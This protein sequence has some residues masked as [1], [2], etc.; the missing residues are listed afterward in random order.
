[1]TK[2]RSGFATVPHGHG[3]MKLITGR[4]YVQGVA[5]VFAI[6]WSSF[7]SCL[8]KFTNYL[9]RRLSTIQ[10]CE[11]SRVKTFTGY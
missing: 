10:Y 8:D 2:N 4:S 3:H 11:F 1:M 5:N 9:K 6:I 7:N